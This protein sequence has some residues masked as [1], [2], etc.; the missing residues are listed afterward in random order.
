MQNLWGA[1]FDEKHLKFLVDCNNATGN[2]ENVFCF[3]DNYIRN[4]IVKLSLLRTWYFS[5]AANVL[6]SSTKIGHVRNGD[7]SQLYWLGSD[8]WIW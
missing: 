2:S 4:G 7:C 8:Q 5:S 3:W 1:S 6:T